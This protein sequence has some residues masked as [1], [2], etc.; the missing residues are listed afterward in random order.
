MRVVR[1]IVNGI[2]MVTLIKPMARLTVARWRKRVQESPAAVIGIPVQELFEAALVQEL[3]PALE[4]L[5][6]AVEELAPAV[7]E[8]EAAA[9]EDIDVVEMAQAAAGRSFIRVVLVAGVVIAVV[10]A[11]AYGVAGLIR[12]RRGAKAS[13]RELV[14][15]PV[16]GGEVEALEDVALEAMAGEG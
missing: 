6:P 16:E 7:E 1:G 15:V 4:A 12:R 13:E 2:L 11:A 10:T 8:L 14:A 3:A 5:A 9:V